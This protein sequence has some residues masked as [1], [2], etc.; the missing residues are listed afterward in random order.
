MCL[1]ACVCICVS[2]HMYVS[3]GKEGWAPYLLIQFISSVDPCRFP[4]CA[5]QY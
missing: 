4:P 3:G 1:Q 5:E 2:V